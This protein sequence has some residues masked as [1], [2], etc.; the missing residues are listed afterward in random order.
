MSTLHCPSCPCDSMLPYEACCG[1]LLRGQ[2]QAE[3]PVALMRSR[4]TAFAEGQTD[5]LFRT[6]HPRTRPA[7]VTLDPS[8]HWVGLDVQE[9]TA[10]SVRFTAHWQRGSESG[11]LSELSRFEQRAGRWFYLDGVVS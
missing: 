11:E 2:S 9:S 6:W 4:Y 7:D 5:Y 3:T 10:D 8:V 1:P